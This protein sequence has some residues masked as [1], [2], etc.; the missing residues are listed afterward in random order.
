MCG[1]FALTLPHEAMRSMFDTHGGADLLVDWPDPAGGGTAAETL[2]AL[3]HPRFNIRPTETIPAVV[4]LEGERCLVPIRWGF[5]PHWAKGLAD[6]SPL[7]NARSETVAEKPAFRKSVRER[8]CLIPADGFYE[9][10]ADAGRGKE[11]HWIF[12]ADGG[13]LAFGG[14]WRV[15]S[16]V[17]KSG[18]PREVASCAIVTTAPSNAMAPLHDRLPLVIGPE[19]FG[20]WLGEGGHGAAALMQPPAEDFY[21]HHPV[22]RLINKGGRA[23]PDGPE[24]REQTEP[25]AALPPEIAASEAAQRLI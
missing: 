2:T 1:R 21:A 13:V 11:P 4:S 18:A 17:D 9:W 16:G 19:D 10:R 8:R 3:D 14:V 7:I 22:S 25:G 12:P 24:L 23:A 20:L 6:G 5:L 15:W